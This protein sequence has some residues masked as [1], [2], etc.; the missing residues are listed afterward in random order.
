MD[1]SGNVFVTGNFNGTAD[2]DPSAS[3]YNLTSMSGGYY[4][5]IAVYST[6]TNP[7]SG[8]TIAA[9]QN[10]TTPFNPAA[11]TSTVAASGHSGT[12]EYKWQ[13]SIT[14]NSAG[15]ADI[16]SSNADTYD[17]G[18]LT[19]TTWFKRLARV[20]CSADWTGAVESNVIEV[21]VT[22]LLPV[23]GI[24]LNGTANDKQVKLGFNALNERE[25]ANYIIERS[26]DGNNFANIG[27]QQPANA[28]Q[29]TTSYSFI[30]NQPIVGN[31]YYRIKGSSINGQI[32]YSNVVLVKYITNAA[33]VNVVPNPIQGKLLQ[34]K[35]S[36]MAKGNYN[37]S[38]IDI[39]GKT[40]LQKEMLLDGNGSVQ[41]N[42]PTS[43][44]AGNYLVKVEGQ[45]SLMVQKF[46]Y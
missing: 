29:A 45:G 42:L 30:D 28:N 39:F 9:A 11:F 27:M 44:K 34:L 6:C 41:L 40:L 37:I 5:F 12:L 14:S 22:S 1:G 7:T 18:A 16:A 17:E 31:N 3:T 43:L 10:G 4:G 25:I 2:F 19:V 21:T 23:A 46:V 20:A 32:Q 8:G 26:T 13:S 33:S 36:Q 38:V 15:F 35:L 24:E